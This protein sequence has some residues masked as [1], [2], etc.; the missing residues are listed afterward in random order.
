MEGEKGKHTRVLSVICFILFVAVVILFFGDVSS[1]Q[2][3]HLMVLAAVLGALVGTAELI[4]RFSQ[5]PIDAIA[6]SA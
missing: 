2:T 4:D 3:A 1:T 6:S 5:K